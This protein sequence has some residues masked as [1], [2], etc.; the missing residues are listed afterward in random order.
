MRD[1]SF[2]QKTIM[3]TFAYIKLRLF[4]KKSVNV[5]NGFLLFIQPASVFL[6]AS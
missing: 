1:F 5:A 4:Q 6:S 3:Q 2:C